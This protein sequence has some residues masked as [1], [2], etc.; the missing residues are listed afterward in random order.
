MEVVNVQNSPWPR[1]MRPFPSFF[2][3]GKSLS[4]QP[5]CTLLGQT[6]NWDNKFKRTS[7]L[8]DERRGGKKKSRERTFRRL[9]ID[10]SKL[11]GEEPKTERNTSN[12]NNKINAYI[13]YIYIF[14]LTF[15]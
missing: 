13:K 3:L 10:F 12:N 15:A 9:A 11:E 8:D 5:G 2:W 7:E 1:V 14:F 6:I 4:R